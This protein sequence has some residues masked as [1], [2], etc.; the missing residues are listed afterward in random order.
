MEDSIFIFLHL[1]EEDYIDLHLSDSNFVID[2]YKYMDELIH[3]KFAQISRY[4]RHFFLFS[5]FLPLRA[6]P[7]P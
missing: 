1:K 4:Y 3:F 7:T 5:F 6:L 2:Y